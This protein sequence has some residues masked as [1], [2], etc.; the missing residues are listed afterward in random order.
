MVTFRGYKFGIGRS[1]DLKNNI[2][3]DPATFD[4]IV[5]IGDL[6]KWQTGCNIMA[7]AALLQ[8]HR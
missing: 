1:F 5:G 8:Q 7:Q 4:H 6:L 2:S 3:A